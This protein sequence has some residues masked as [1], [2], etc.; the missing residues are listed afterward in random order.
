VSNN[1]KQII[2]INIQYKQN[3]ILY[4]I[5]DMPVCSDRN[6]RFSITLSLK[7]FILLFI[8]FFIVTFIGFNVYSKNDIR[9]KNLCE[10]YN[11]I[12][13]GSS[14]LTYVIM[15]SLSIIFTLMF[16]Y[17]TKR[18][19]INGGKGISR[20]IPPGILF[21]F[22]VMCILFT[23]LLPKENIDF[24]NVDD[25]MD[26]KLKEWCSHESL[27]LKM[28][29][30]CGILFALCISICIILISEWVGKNCVF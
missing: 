5:R 8:S 30:G 20:F 16:L 26:N 1:I 10:E 29:W 28:I 24:S 4:L 6:I 3:K 7:S 22:S 21:I 12:Y 18:S 14:K 9:K 11:V 17:F 23:V 13:S 19:I 27:G 15:I 25:N 2:F